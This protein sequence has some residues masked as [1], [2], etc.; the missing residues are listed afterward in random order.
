MKCVIDVNGSPTWKTLGS[1]VLIV[2]RK[3]YNRVMLSS[4][5]DFIMLHYLGS[6]GSRLG[7]SIGSVA[8]QSEE[9]Q[10]VERLRADVL[11]S[12]PIHANLVFHP[13]LNSARHDWEE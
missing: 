11:G 7:S 12:G 6:V 2:L 3:T 9:L 5:S 8:A 13:H 10:A 1:V 4:F